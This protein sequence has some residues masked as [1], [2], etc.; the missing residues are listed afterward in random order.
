MN[1]SILGPRVA[2][3]IR[4]FTTAPSSVVGGAWTV[5]PPTTRTGASSS[6]L[7][8]SRPR[9][10]TSSCSPAST[11]YCFPP[12]RITAYIRRTMLVHRPQQ[13][14]VE[15]EPPAVAGGADLAERLHQTLG[16]PLA[17]HLDQ[18]Q[19]RHLER[20]GTGLVA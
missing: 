11:L 3:T 17:G 2:P 20:L 19:L 10:S 18:P 14:F 5:S 6:S 4:A 16:D 13:G 9:R 8:S 15:D 12:V 1:P 7:P